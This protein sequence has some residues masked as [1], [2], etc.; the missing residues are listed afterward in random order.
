M[1]EVQDLDT[2]QGSEISEID[3]VADQDAK[4]QSAAS[5]ESPEQ[6]KQ[7]EIP[8]RYRGKSMKQLVDELEHANKSMGRYSNELGEVRRLADELIKSQLMP[9]KQAEQPKE[10]DFFENPQ[11]A[12]RRAVESNP[13]L[14]QAKQYALQ[15]KQAQAKAEFEKRHPDF[16]QVLQEKEFGEWI[17]KSQIR[18]KLWQSAVN[19][20]V[21]AADE[22]FSTYKELKAVKAVKQQETQAAVSETEKAARKEAL[23]AASVQTGGTGEATRKIFRRADLINLRLRDPRKFASMQDEIDA[24]YREGRVK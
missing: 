10:V 3:A 24:A 19:F 17:Q 9:Q 14:Q 6:S 1:A 8:E 20:D 12:I 21:A 16:G 7:D 15:A 23:S 11:E 5:S 4:A 2:D 22:L 18:T 13:E